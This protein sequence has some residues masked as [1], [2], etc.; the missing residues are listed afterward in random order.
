MRKPDGS[1]ECSETLNIS[2]G[3]L[4]GYI[5]SAVTFI[6]GFM[7]IFKTH[8]N[9]NER[10]HVGTLPHQVKIYSLEYS[11]DAGL[12]DVNIQEASSRV[13]KIAT[14]S[15]YD[16]TM[17]ISIQKTK[18]MYI[19]RKSESQKQPTMILTSLDFEHICSDCQQ[20][21]HTNM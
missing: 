14:G 20:D 3:V 17:E 10:F 15:R 19:I 18:A 21:F 8:D 13:T 11:D 12:V 9:P 7:H 5:F 4:Q 16:A 2:S 6:T 1:E